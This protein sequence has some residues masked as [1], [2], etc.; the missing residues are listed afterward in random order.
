[1]WNHGYRLNCWAQTPRID[2]R[3]GGVDTSL[4]NLPSGSIKDGDVMTLRARGN[5]IQALVNGK[6]VLSVIDND[7]PSGS[8]VGIAKSSGTGGQME[9]LVVSTY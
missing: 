3:F 7:I 8:F 2:K 6:V 1:M 9:Q 4:G 5:V